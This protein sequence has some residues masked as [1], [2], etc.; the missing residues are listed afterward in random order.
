MGEL[1]DEIGDRFDFS[2]TYI[3]KLLLREHYDLSKNEEI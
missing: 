1:K 3:P 2:W